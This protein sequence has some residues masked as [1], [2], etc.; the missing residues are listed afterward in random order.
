MKVPK[1][2]KY[3]M[4]VIMAQTVYNT[5][6][7]KYY[8][9]VLIKFIEPSLCPPKAL[10]WAQLT[11][12]PRDSAA[13]HV[14]HSDF[15]HG[16]SQRQ[17]APAR[18]ILTKRSSTNLLITDVTNWRLWFDLMVD[19][20]NSCFNYSSS[21]AAVLCYVARSKNIRAYCHCVS[22]VTIVLWQK[23]HLANN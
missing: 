10:S 3:T 1:S 5:M 9:N 13:E 6:C 18:R 8:E 12:L 16:W 11:T 22:S 2:N 15:Q 17:C 21:Y 14:S 19:T 7:F 4:Y 23:V 20:L